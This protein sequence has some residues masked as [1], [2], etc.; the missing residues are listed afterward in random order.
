MAATVE[1][2]ETVR[3]VAQ[4]RYKYGFVTEIETET[5]LWLPVWSRARCGRGEDWRRSW[6]RLVFR[7]NWP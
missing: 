1:T 6:P 2:V 7:L 5:R 3:E 4:E